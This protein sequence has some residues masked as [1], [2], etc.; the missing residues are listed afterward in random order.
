MTPRLLP[1]VIFAVTLTACS[2]GDD[3]AESEGKFDTK[4]VHIGA[5]TADTAPLREGDVRIVTNENSVDLLL[6]GDSISS[7]L[8]PSAL[9]KAR[10]STDTAEVKG[11]GFGSFI[12][13]TVKSSVQGALGTR[14]G[15]G[16][17]DING[18]RYENGRIDFDWVGSKK[19][20]FDHTKV[21]NRPLLE[22]FSPTDAQTLVNAVNA[23]KGA[24]AR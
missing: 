15:F 10:H 16:L 6:R 12:E 14:V 24:V 19:S 11:S 20:I 1:A 22:S 23:R 13:K 17:S 2:H 4:M 5:A 21:N 18:A 7:G 8:S 9:A 3:K